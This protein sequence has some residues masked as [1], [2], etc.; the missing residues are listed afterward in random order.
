MKTVHLLS[1]HYIAL[2][3]LYISS[4]T[5]YPPHR[6]HP[7]NAN[8][9]IYILSKQQ[10]PRCTRCYGWLKTR[11][12][13][14]SPERPTPILFV[15]ARSRSLAL[16]EETEPKPVGGERPKTAA[17]TFAIENH[18]KIG[19]NANR[20]LSALHSRVTKRAQS[21]KASALCRLPS[22]P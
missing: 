7:T 8:S 16:T 3:P 20:R 9:I 15:S 14:F 5:V 6:T 2:L 1:S 17:V 19:E 13:K 21:L 10:A 4:G 11:I 18:M 12:S 22:L